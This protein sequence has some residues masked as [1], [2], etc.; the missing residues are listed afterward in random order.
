MPAVGGNAPANTEFAKRVE[1]EVRVHQVSLFRRDLLKHIA[2][3]G[4]FEV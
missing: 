2:K 1:N 3:P 4:W